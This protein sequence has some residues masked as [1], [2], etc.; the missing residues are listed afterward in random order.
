MTS[1]DAEPAGTPGNGPGPS[2]VPLIAPID[3]LCARLYLID[4]AVET[5]DM[6]YYEWDSDAVGLLVL[7]RVV[8]AADRDVRVRLLV[9]DL[10]LW[11][12]TKRIKSLCRHPNID[13]RVFNPW[14]TRSGLAAIAY[15]GMRRFGRLDHRMHNKLLLTDGRRAVFGGRNLAE[16]YFGLSDAYN[17]IDFDVLAD[18][19]PLSRL[20]AEFDRYWDADAAVDGS[21]L[22]GPAPLSV[23]EARSSVSRD[24]D[25]HASRLAGVLEHEAPFAATLEDRV[26]P[27]ER[28]HL[29]VVTDTPSVGSA[30]PSQVHHALRDLVEGAADDVIAITAFFDPTSDDIA[31]Y[32]SLVESGVRVRL[33]TNSLATNPGTASNAG[34]KKMRR[35][36]VDAGL[37]LH[38]L[39]PHPATQPEWETPPVSGRYLGIHAKIYVVD[40][41]RTLIGS[42]NLDPRS[43]HINTEIGVIL[44][45]AGFAEQMA[46]GIEDLMKPEN[47][48][49]VITDDGSG[50]RW[51]A[52]GE[53]LTRQPARGLGQRLADGALGFLPIDR[54][55]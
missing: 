44:S 33:L 13:I 17:L 32:R 9:D 50:V 41:Q 20:T 26:I 18:A 16:S 47:A 38:E 54:Y 36:L 19:E 3:G 5:I 14:A 10:K 1:S 49:R 6:Q 24:L 51:Q 31:W 45:H 27:L 40:R 15:E 28:E 4:R 23:A 55:L 29:T 22:R 52:D 37:E 48:W 46:E 11:K 12:S 8:A 30:S 25:S 2:L 35:A 7:D 42:T 39:K 21:T 53:I 34:L 43:K